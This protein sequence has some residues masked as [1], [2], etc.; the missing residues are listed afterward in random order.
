MN[1]VKSSKRKMNRYVKLKI[2][3]ML[4]NYLK[5][6]PPKIKEEL[7]DPDMCMCMQDLIDDTVDNFWPDLEDYIL[8][9]FRL[10]MN[11]PVLKE[12]PRKTYL[13]ICIPCGRLRDCFR[14]QY[15]PVDKVIWNRI[16][17]FWF[18][19]FKLISSF[20]FY[21]V[22]PIFKGIVW[23]MIDKSDEFQ[24]VQFILNFKTL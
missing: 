14:Y 4:I 24:L 15:D 13:G 3:S 6:M 7:K 5:K 10:S 20:P 19:V 2:E 12:T 8:F 22:Q 11:K 21:A 16:K 18:W 1:I 17:T 23:I 9:E